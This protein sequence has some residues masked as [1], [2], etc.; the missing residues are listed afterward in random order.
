LDIDLR[1][2][3]WALRRSSGLWE[4]WKDA[5][6]YSR[7]PT[8]EE[9]G[10]RILR[11]AGLSTNM[12]QVVVAR[13]PGGNGPIYAIALAKLGMHVD[14]IG[15]VGAEAVHPMFQDFAG[16][17]RLH[18]ICEPAL[19]EALEFE[20]GKLICSKLTAFDGFTWE[21]LK[22]R[23]GVEGL[24]ALMDGAD[25]LSFNNWTMLSA[26]NDCWRHLLEE[27]IPCMKKPPASKKVF[28][29]LA[30]PEKRRREDL[31]EALGLIRRFESAGFDTTLGLNLKEAR[32]V[33]SALGKDGD[34]MGLREL[35]T[36]LGE[37]LKLS[38][39]AVHPTE[40]AACFRKG[41][42]FEVQVPSVGI[43]RLQRGTGITLMPGLCL[44]W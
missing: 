21:S 35:V 36:E 43:R 2:L 18:G 37:E 6:H 33:L 8:I 24:A 4:G 22:E 39:I 31:L 7:I 15:A 30:D 28:F 40:C 14:Y 26:M 1:R 41:R 23:A 17:A 20:D 13:K 32:Q 27:V 11:S 42:Y 29:D 44:L 19:T 3:F 12:E 16:E 5:R 38:S 9:Y 25:L 34:S 10:K